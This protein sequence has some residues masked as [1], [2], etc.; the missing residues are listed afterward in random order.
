MSFDTDPVSWITTGAVGEPGERTFYLQAAL[1]SQTCALV[2]EKEQVDALCRYVHAMLVRLGEQ[3]LED[4]PAGVAP[5]LIEPL[6]PVFRIGQMSLGYD[7]ERDLILVQCEQL[8]IVEDE[9]Q[10][11]PEPERVR[12]WVNRG[13][14]RALAATGAAAVASGRPRCPLCGEPLDPDGHFCVASNGHREVQQIE[15]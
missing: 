12:F 11:P 8:V 2:L 6:E 14:I 7:A 1:G 5:D 4:S 3:P 10:V 15:E 13:Q 9:D